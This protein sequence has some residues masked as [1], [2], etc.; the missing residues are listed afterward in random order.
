[1]PPLLLV[2][3]KCHAVYCRLLTA[4]MKTMPNIVKDLANL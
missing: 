4:K 1:M 2:L 3:L